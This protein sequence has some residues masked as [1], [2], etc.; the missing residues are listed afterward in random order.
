MA[1]AIISGDSLYGQSH[2]NLGQFFR[3][4]P[5]TGKVIWF[6]PERMGNYATF[7]STSENVFAQRVDGRL[8]V[9]KSGDDIYRPLA[10]YKT[11][12]QETW[13]APVILPDGLLIKDRSTLYRWRF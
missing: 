4:N 9:L 12:S 7:L 3:L 5:L 10:T 13:A 8:I 2:L 1:S 11:A 6:G